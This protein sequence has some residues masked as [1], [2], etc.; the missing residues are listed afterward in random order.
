MIEDRNLTVGTRL[1]ATFHKKKHFCEV[2]QASDGLGY[3]L[4]STGVI[5]KSL[6]SAG[7]AVMDGVACNGWRFWSIATEENSKEVTVAP[8][9]DG[10]APAT[11]KRVR[12]APVVASSTEN[13]ETTLEDAGA[14]TSTA[15]VKRTKVIRKVANQSGAPEGQT[16]FFCVACANSFDAPTTGTTPE[17]CPKGHAALLDEHGDLVT[18]A[19][20]V[21]EAASEGETAGL[22]APGDPELVAEVE[23][24]EETAT[25]PDGIPAQE[26]LA[27]ILG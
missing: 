21:T 11:A 15:K 12:K 10:A 6:S 16:R 4:N 18:K 20:D 22:E 14:A 3:Q 1:V 24:T 25:E 23:Q 7:S 26:D 13:I 19:P 8:V 5:Y 2:V 9:P 17:Y 27:E